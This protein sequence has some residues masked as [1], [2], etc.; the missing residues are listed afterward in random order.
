VRLPTSHKT[1][2]V[3]DTQVIDV[4]NDHLCYVITERRTP[5]FLP[6]AKNFSIISKIVVTHVAKSKCKFAIYAKVEWQKRPLLTRRLVER[7][8]LNDAGVLARSL[9]DILMDQIAML[10]SSAYNNSRKAVQ[11]FGN[12]GQTKDILQPGLSDPTASSRDRIRPRTLASLVLFTAKTSLV[13][14]LL[15]SLGALIHLAQALAKVASAHHVL[16]MVLAFSGVM[17]FWFAN[18]DTWGWYR[19]RQAKRF[20]NDIGV[21]PSAALGRSVWLRDLDILSTPPLATS[22]LNITTTSGETSSSPCRQNFNALLSQ[23]DPSSPPLTP[24]SMQQHHQDLD[25]KTLSR[26][27]RTRHHFGT[28]RHDLLVALRVIDR[29][30]KDTIIAEWESWVR[31]EVGRCRASKL[32]VDEAASDEGMREWWRSYCGSC[33]G[34]NRAIG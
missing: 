3:T 1:F 22:A 25:T 32:I 13:N 33:E 28:Y 18:K 8:A 29:V 14:A 19:E 6:S 21:H 20:M 7:Q 27:Q 11:I 12:V 17:N 23:T 30:E 31:S 15:A 4:F 16:V 9:T 5:W 34:E 26:L 10:G 24:G 2:E